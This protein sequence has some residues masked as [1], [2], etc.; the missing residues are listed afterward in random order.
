M[1][2]CGICNQTFEKLGSYS[3]H[4][5]G[6]SRRGDMPAVGA[7][8]PASRHCESCNIEFETAFKFAGHRRLMH[9]EWNS[10]KTDGRRK[11]RLIGER[12]RCCEVCSLTEWCGQPTPIEIDHIDGNPE[13]TDKENFRLICPNCHAQTSTYKGRNIGKVQNSKRAARLKQHYGKYR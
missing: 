10:I 11:A 9:C 2:H 13:N 4:R 6:H 12:G 5:S 3:G 8:K 7:R 1:Y